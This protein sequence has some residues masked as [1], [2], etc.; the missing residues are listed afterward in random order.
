MFFVSLAS[1]F[2]V[3]I[4]FRFFCQKNLADNCLRELNA[5]IQ[6]AKTVRQDLEE[7]MEDALSISKIIAEDIDDKIAA[8][9]DFSL[10]V[11]N[12]AED[13]QVEILQ[14][15]EPIISNKIR[16]YEL[17]QELGISSR[18]LVNIVQDLGIEA[19]NHMNCLDENQ[20][21][22]I[23]K[24]L[25]IFPKDAVDIIKPCLLKKN[26]DSGGDIVKAR[27]KNDRQFDISIEEL[28]LAHPYLAV[29]TLQERGYSVRD[30]AQI[31]ERGQ[32]EVSLIIKLSPKKQ[33]FI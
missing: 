19:F 3:V 32:G 29:R 22:V 8:V 11:P 6:E 20:V 17:A 33:A 27:R 18:S 5:S 10:L 7:M 25:Q 24:S 26:M 31:L 2:M 12:A 23:K 16:I 21:L 13:K 9:S 28:K 14:L 4:L 1:L 15:Q 30:I